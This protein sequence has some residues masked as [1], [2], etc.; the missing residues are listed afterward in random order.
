MKSIK[1]GRGPSKMSAV[2]SIFVAIFGIFWCIVAGSMGAVF[3]VPFGLLFVGLAVYNAA[4]RY[5]NA[6]SEK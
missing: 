1:S 6:T 3:M 4:Y 5:R 2:G